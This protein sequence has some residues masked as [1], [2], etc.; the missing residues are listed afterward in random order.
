[1][2]K[3]LRFTVTVSLRA[4]DEGSCLVQR[5]MISL[6]VT[7]FSPF[8][9]ST[10]LSIRYLDGFRLR[11]ESSSSA[12]PVHTCLLSLLAMAE[13]ILLAHEYIDVFF[14]RFENSVSTSMISCG[15]LLDT[16]KST[17]CTLVTDGNRGGS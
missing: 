14:D 9:G 15:S 5:V 10:I 3:S 7:S 1:M 13:T 8:L 2:D 16:F 4:V 6:S 12:L 11:L 17:I